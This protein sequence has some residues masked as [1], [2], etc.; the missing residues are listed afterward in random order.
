MLQQFKMKAKNLK[1]KLALG[2]TMALGASAS[3]MADIAAVETA[4]IAKVGEAESFG[5]NILAVALVA[6]VGIGLVKKFA[7]KAA[8]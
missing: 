8:S 1:A 5:F 6:I 7:T 4:I 3:A 2:T